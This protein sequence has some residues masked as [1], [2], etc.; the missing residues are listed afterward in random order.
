MEHCGESLFLGVIQMK[1]TNRVREHRVN[2]RI[3]KIKDSYPLTN[4]YDPDNM[5]L[6][7]EL[8]TPPKQGRRTKPRCGE[9]RSKRRL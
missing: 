9:L 4:F 3:T 5:K 2:N 7:A 8:Y 6:D 1:K